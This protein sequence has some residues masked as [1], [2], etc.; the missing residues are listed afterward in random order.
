MMFSGRILKSLSLLAVLAAAGCAGQRPTSQT[1]SGTYSVT[2]D[3][4]SALVSVHT[5]TGRLVLQDGSE[6]AFKAD[7][8]SLAG[9][10]YSIA[11]ATGTVYNLQKP[12]DLS[13][14]YGAVGGAAIVIHGGGSAGL[15]NRGNDV[16]LDVDSAETGLR[17]GLGGGFV[18]FSLGEQL[19]GPRVA[20]V[21]PVTP[22]PAAPIATPAQPVS[23]SIEFGY[24]KSRVSLAIGK[25]LDPIVATWRDKPVTFN[26]VGHADTVGTDRYNNVLS[27]QRAQNVKQALIERGVA[28][29]RITATG[30]GEAGLAVP[31]PEDTRLRANRRVVITITATR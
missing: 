9:L 20:A 19:K 8:Y 27:K 23:H 3:N 7:G 22:K 17:L 24:D 14:E 12:E 6:Y 10:G 11:T 15:K 16:F 4:L 25:Q 21:Q 31:T 28:A 30:V 1:P 29:N 18:T 5:G 2:Y 13:G 26:V